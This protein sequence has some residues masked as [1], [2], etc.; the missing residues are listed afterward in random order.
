MYAV[1]KNINS[2]CIFKKCSFFIK[3]YKF[4]LPANQ[5]QFNSNAFEN[6]EENLHLIFF[7]IDVRTDSKRLSSEYHVIAGRQKDVT[8]P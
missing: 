6:F 2:S 3:F 1:L 7:Q 5:K 8:H 4:N